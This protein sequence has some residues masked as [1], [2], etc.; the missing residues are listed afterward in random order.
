MTKKRTATFAL[1]LLAALSAFGLSYAGARMGAASDRAA[2]P[3]SAVIEQSARLI[4]IPGYEAIP[5]KA[6]QEKQTVSFYNPAGNSCYFE[7]SLILDGT[8][9]FTSELIAP[10]EEVK[11]IRLEQPLAAG[12]YYDAQL[13]YRS[14]ALD[15]MEEL[16]GAEVVTI[17]EVKA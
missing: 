14:F 7:L 5:L 12:V 16:N 15:S 1:A 6:G 11:S 13:R 8:E 10:G 2:Q 3:E 9:L 17:L 4:T